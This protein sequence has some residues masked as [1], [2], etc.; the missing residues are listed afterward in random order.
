MCQTWMQSLLTW[1]P[2]LGWSW[3]P[4]KQVIGITMGSTLNIWVGDRYSEAATL[5]TVIPSV[6]ALAYPLLNLSIH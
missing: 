2:A 4:G 1:L 6:L 3:G 5:D